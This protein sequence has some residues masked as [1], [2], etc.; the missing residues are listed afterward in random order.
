[1]MTFFAFFGMPTLCIRDLIQ[2]KPGTL[3]DDCKGRA[4]EFKPP[5]G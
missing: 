2:P 4:P 3:A 1:M 5:A